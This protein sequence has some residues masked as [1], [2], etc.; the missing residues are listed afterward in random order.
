MRNEMLD[1]LCSI[2]R[3]FLRKYYVVDPIDDFIYTFGTRKECEDVIIWLQDAISAG[4]IYAIYKKSELTP[5]MLQTINPG[6]SLITEIITSI[7]R[8]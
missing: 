8:N 2:R 5:S 7:P 3:K 1:K 4:S 6:Q